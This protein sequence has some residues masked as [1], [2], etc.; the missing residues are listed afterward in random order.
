MSQSDATSVTTSSDVD[1]EDMILDQPI[2]YVLNQFLTTDDGVNVATCLHD[3]AK[4]VKEL[5]KTLSAFL[6]AQSGQHH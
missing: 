1:V 4:E 5:R 2:Y 3:L 6:K